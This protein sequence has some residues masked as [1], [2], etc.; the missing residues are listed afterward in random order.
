[1]NAAI[2]RGLR[3]A[4][5]LQLTGALKT[6]ISHWLFLQ[7]WDEPLPWRQEKH[8][9][10]FMFTDASATGWGGTLLSPIAT[11]T[12]DYWVGVERSWD[13][14]TKEA[15]ALDRMLLSHRDSLRDSRVDVYIDNQAVIHAWNNQGGRGAMLNNALKKIFFTTVDLN[16][17]LRLIYVSTVDNLADSPSRRLSYSDSRLS[18]DV[19]HIVQRE[20]GGSHGHTFDLM[21]LD[22]NAMRDTTGH[23][24]PHFTPWFS[25]HSAGVNFFSQDLSLYASLMQRPYVFPP[26]SLTGPVLSFLAGSAQACTVIV[27]DIYPRKYWWPLLQCKSQKALK[28]APRGSTRAL[29]VPFKD[30]WISHPGIPGDLWA[31]AF[32]G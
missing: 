10:V 5:P 23:I 15:F 9:N 27:F 2:S 29:L 24:L 4:R 21:A 3:S 6:E 32:Y 26:I 8:V 30:G 12:S 17:A 1:M 18:L 22:S 13:I 16:V 14:A 25:P 31:F 20:F 19:W 11:N 7:D 28:L